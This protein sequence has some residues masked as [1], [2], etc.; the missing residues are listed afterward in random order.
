M[1]QKKNIM[2]GLPN[3]ARIEDYFMGKT[4]ATYDRVKRQYMIW[5]SITQRVL[6][7]AGLQKGMHCLEFGSGAGS[8]MRLMGRIVGNEGSVT[9]I[10]SDLELGNYAVDI[11]NGQGI[12]QYDFIHGSIEEFKTMPGGPYDFIFARFLLTRVENPE[13]ALRKLFHSLKPGG[14]LLIQD[15]DFNT[16]HFSEPVRDIDV[17]F[18]ELMM[19][20]L[21]SSGKDPVMGIR[22]SDYFKKAL[23]KEADQTDASGVISTATEAISMMCSVYENMLPLLKKFGLA[24]DDNFT[25][26]CELTDAILPEVKEVTA[27]WPLLGSAWIRRMITPGYFKEAIIHERFGEL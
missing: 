15:Y 10:D 12:T 5:E 1:P 19:D 20:A 18:R 26:F 7:Q 24:D 22:L 4:A 27:F 16:F 17:H 9:G 25:S 21:K 11:L 8:V 3:A 6:Q 13:E 23:G 14:V 2:S